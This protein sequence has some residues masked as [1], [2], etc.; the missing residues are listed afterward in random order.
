MALPLGHQI[1]GAAFTGSTV[2]R[3]SPVWIRTM[4]E[5]VAPAPAELEIKFKLPAGAETKLAAHP[6]LRSET[7]KGVKARHEVT[8][9]FDTAN[10]DLARRGATLRVRV[11]SKGRVQTLK[12]RDDGDSLFGRGE[13]EWP[14]ESNTPDPAKLAATPLASLLDKLEV[15]GPVFTTEVDRTVRTLRLDDAEIETAIDIGAIRAGEAVEEIR[16]LELELKG[17]KVAALYKLATQLGAELQLTLGV[18]SK[19]DRGWRLST[20]HTRTPEKAGDILLPSKVT[21]A[22]AIR[23]IVGMTLANLLANL[24]AAAAGR[25]EGVHNMRIAIRRLRTALALFQPYLDKATT[26]RFTEGLR[27]LGRVLGE[28]RDWDVFCTE[29][30]A[31]AAEA[32]VAEE[33]LND[34]RGPAAI[35]RTRAHASLGAALAGPPLTALVLELAAWVEDPAALAGSPDGGDLH[36]PLADL[37]PKL[38]ERLERKA[39]RRGRHIRRRS[40][41]ELHDLRKSLKKLRYGVEFLAPLH[42]R[43]QVRAFLHGCKA[44]QQHLGTMN[45]AAVAETL[46]KRLGAGREAELARTAGTLGSWAERRRTEAHRHLRHAWHGFKATSLPN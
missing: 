9:Y 23:R 3:P 36:T 12:L 39:R 44:L 2:V 37:V 10:R 30:L 6:A 35:E 8:T 7:G 25:I 11:G 46:V 21:T 19:A 32:G 38:E 27:Q 4:I 29:T 17:G 34:L 33:L 28:A 13:W 45:D 40:A 31:A 26:A 5:D 24:P 20:G 22:E 14:L 1:S 41:E 18:E 43:K 42:R 16:E 15:L